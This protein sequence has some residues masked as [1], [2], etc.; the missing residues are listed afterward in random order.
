MWWG[1]LVVFPCLPNSNLFWCRNGKSIQVGIK[2]VKKTYHGVGA[3]ERA[4]YLA[5][6]Y[7]QLHEKNVPHVDHLS[8]FVDGTPTVYLEPKGIVA[9]PTNETE[10]LE[11]LVCVLQALQ[12]CYYILRLTLAFHMS[13]VLHQD[14]PVFHR[15]IRWANVIRSANDRSS[16]FLIDWEDAVGR[17]NTAATHLHRDS[18]SPRLYFD[19]HGG[20]VDVWRVG[21]LIKESRSFAFNISAELLKVGRWMQD[22]GPTSQN[23]LAAIMKYKNDL[24]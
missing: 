3:A 18:H 14:P 2:S 8:H 7:K 5:H 6:I 16:W 4:R 20:E 21:L 12:V 24:G 10:L 9:Q 13:Q 1:L 15:D 19:N 22:E 23:A 17:N 11:A